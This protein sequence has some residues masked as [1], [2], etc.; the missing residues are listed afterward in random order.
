MLFAKKVMK[1]CDI[2]KLTQATF[3]R[4]SY[5]QAENQ[6]S[7]EL[8]LEK[9]LQFIFEIKKALSANSFEVKDLV[10]QRNQSTQIINGQFSDDSLFNIA[11]ATYSS[12]QE[13]YFKVEVV[14][15]DNMVQYDSSAD[16]AF[17]GF[18]YQADYFVSDHDDIAVSEIL[19]K[20]Q[21]IGGE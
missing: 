15:K 5:Y 6:D 20:F 17:S 14:A 18:D 8:I 4:L 13:P 7:S 2:N 16:S 11:L 12:V 19:K 1:V 3:L 10:L 21:L 9:G